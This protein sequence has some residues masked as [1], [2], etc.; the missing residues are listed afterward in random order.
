MNKVSNNSLTSRRQTTI[1]IC[2]LPLGNKDH[3]IIILMAN[4]YGPSP[5]LFSS[6]IHSKDLLVGFV[7]PFAFFMRALLSSYS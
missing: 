4:L 5:F 7:G 1:L 2:F 3:Y 6:I